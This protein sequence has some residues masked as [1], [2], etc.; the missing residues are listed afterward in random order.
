MR[1]FLAILFDEATRM[2]LLKLQNQL[3][4]AA[5]GN[6]T[7]PEN[8]HLT[9]LFLG[10]VSQCAGICAI[11]QRRFSRPILL[12]FDRAGNFGGN[13]YWAGIRP[14]PELDGLYGLLLRDVRAE[15][16]SG[17]FPERIHPHV[18]LAR[19]VALRAQP[20]LRFEPFSMQARRLSVMRSRRT[21]EGPVYEELFAARV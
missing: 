11:A 5:D 21:A 16:F 15:G 2:R 6:F 10:E 13:L 14:N 3:R 4:Q 17:N 9:V 19:K 18:T 1:L 20:E 8:L 12:E 7:R